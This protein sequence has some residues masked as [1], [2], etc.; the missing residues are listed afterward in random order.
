AAA[1]ASP[2]ALPPLRS[3]HTENFPANLD[4]FGVSLLV[5]TYQAGKLV[6]VRSE[7]SGLNTLFRGFN[8][9]MGVA[10]DRDRIAVGTG[11]EIWEFHNVPAVARKLPPAG[12]HDACYL[13]RACHVTGD[14]QIHEMAW[15]RAA[16]WFVNTRFS[17]L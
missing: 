9:P 10:V 17:C 3:V 5:S 13:P 4:T 6:V 12:R 2:A 1:G 16:L 7:G 15:G 8:R 11:V 14:V